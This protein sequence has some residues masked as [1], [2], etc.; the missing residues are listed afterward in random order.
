ML[1][2]KKVDSNLAFY[3][4]K[5]IY[6]NIKFIKLDNRRMDMYLYN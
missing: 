4:C 5:V 3:G 1:F 6:I 2:K